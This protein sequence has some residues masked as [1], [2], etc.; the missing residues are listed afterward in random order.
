MPPLN[1]F[2]IRTTICLVAIFCGDPWLLA[3]DWPMWRYDAYRSAASPHELPAELRLSWVHQ[4][5]Q[6]EQVWDDPLNQDLMPYDRIF[7]PIILNDRMFFGFNDRDKVVAIDL[8]SGRQLW[9]FFTDGP[10]R[11]PPAA[12][13]GKVLFTS[14]DGY[15]Y[16]VNAVDGQLLW[17]FR[18]G[19]SNQKAIGNHRVISAWPARGGPVIRD[20]HVY[21][22]ASIWPFM[23]TFLYALDVETGN[24]IWVNDSTSA[25]Y[26]KQPHGSPS[27]AGVGPQGALVA[28]Q[29]V[30]LVPGGRSVPAAFERTTGKFMHFTIGGKGTGGSFVCADEKDFYVHTRRRGVRACDLQSGKKSKH[31]VNEP[32]LVDSGMVSFDGSV[33]QAKT[34][35]STFSTAVDA[36]GDVIQVGS[37]IY[38]AGKDRITAVDQDGQV[39]WSQPVR[40]QVLRLLAGGGKLVAVTKDGRILVY[41]EK[42]VLDQPLR[43]SFELESSEAESET[44]A[45]QLI[46]RTAATEGY[47]IWYGAD[48]ARL[49]SS[50]LQQSKLRIL[51]V[52]PRDQRVKELRQ[53]FDAA[54]QYG[55]RITVHK[56]H[57]RSFMAPPYIANLVVVGPSLT[58][59]DRLS[60]DLKSLYQSVRPYGGALW[61]SASSGKSQHLVKLVERQE[62]ENAQT[63][64]YDEGVLVVRVGPLAGAA[65]WTHQYGDIANTVKSNDQ[66]VKLPLGV[67]WFGGSSNLDVLPRHGHGPPE[68]VVGGRT[69]VEGIDSLSARDT[70]TGRVLWKRTFDSLE[71]FGV[72]FDKTY[73]ETPLSTAYNQ[74]HIPGANGRGT[75]Y[76]ATEK[77]IFVILGSHCEVLDAR[78]GATVRQISMP[79]REPGRGA[80]LWGFVG[81]Y[82]DVLLGGRGFSNYSG[83]KRDRASRQELSIL[84]MSASDGLV[85]FDRETGRVRWQLDSRFSFLHNGIV[86]GRGRVYCLDKLPN[87]VEA[88]LRRR[89]MSPDQKYRLVALD[90][91]TGEL[92][93]EREADIFGTWLGY[94]EEHDVLLQAGALAGDRLRDEVGQG[95][96]T[97][98]GADGSVIWKDL[99]LAYTGPCI[100]HHDTIITNANSYQRSSGAYNLLDGSPKLI[101]NPLT[102]QQVPWQFTRNYGCN[103]AI[104]SE[105][106]LTFRSGA[107]GFYDLTG[108]SGTGNFGGFRSSCTSNLVAAGGLL[109]APDYTR[110][111]SCSYQNQT[112]LA[113]VHMPG[114]ETWTNSVYG[115]EDRV[116]RIGI[117]FGA[118]GDRLSDAGTMWLDYPSVGG[119]SPQVMVKLSGD[120]ASYFRR[121]VSAIDTDDH[122]WVASSGVE[123]VRTV[124]LRVANRLPA[125]SEL[126][127]PIAA[128][129]DD[130]E[131]RSDGS[132]YLNSSDLELSEDASPQLVGMRFTKI[133]LGPDDEI[134]DARIQFTTKEV[135]E[136]PVRLLIQAVAA[137]DAVSFNARTYDISSRSKTTATVV[138]SPG[139]WGKVDSRGADQRTPNLKELVNEVIHRPGWKR[140]NAIAFVIS[141]KGKRTAVSRENNAAQAS[142][143]KIKLGDSSS[144]NNSVVAKSASAHYTVRLYFAEPTDVAQGERVFDVALQ[145][146]TVLRNFDVVK[147]AGNSLRTVVQQ[148]PHIDVKDVLEISLTPKS[149]GSVG[150]ILNGVELVSE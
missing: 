64:V 38:A 131:E 60:Q 87:S 5:T 146:Q 129:R 142:Q 134:Q 14:D 94:S 9:Q 37:R 62:L 137:D 126:V 29:N 45:A 110:T 106:L 105:H 50:V 130:A 71:N 104:A 74:V 80:P 124:S 25:Q 68:Q 67:L 141:G 4:Y 140:G 135:G 31:V 33:L 56:G 136:D 143:L 12:A 91:R 23:G 125:V 43:E 100:L 44:S 76:V 72:Y 24:L 128:D 113:L 119:E 133:Q 21:F 81:I 103:T 27:F 144:Q 39:M 114:L 77:E 40:G 61:L 6:R 13:D 59:Q 3:G 93:W 47:A 66:R 149:D 102:G 123:N 96:I 26:I 92:L 85:V 101:T 41:G 19:P 34:K 70:Y 42:S 139:P 111:C 51:V 11:F 7:E 127:I 97:Y 49:L 28:T 95:M 73:K 57:P 90:V 121:H 58:E 48:D 79:S 55:G 17:R 112:S 52:E 89:G 108:L 98:H 69:I 99:Q 148:F 65:D 120:G 16:C 54:G 10:V 36:G 84:D 83:K 20:G 115:I 22:A 107:A 109:N 150:P 63:I 82:K 122:P 8:Q 1:C 132:M 116:R 86:A 32:V 138:W 75:N 147:Q 15:L 145:G 78:T 2:A 46:D 118:P 53:A 117:N 30:L 35:T 88:G 18:G